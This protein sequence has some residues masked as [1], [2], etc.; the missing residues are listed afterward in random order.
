MEFSFGTLVFVIEFTVYLYIELYS[1]YRYR[2]FK[3][4]ADLNLLIAFSL[5]LLTAIERYYITFLTDMA[6]I[7]GIY[8][9]INFFLM[10]EIFFMY[11]A[12]T[13]Y[14]ENK[15]TTSVFVFAFISGIL[16]GAFL[17]D[18][19][20][21][22]AYDATTKNYNAVYS[23]AL[24][25]FIAPLI[26][27][28][29][30][31]IVQPL[32]RKSKSVVD[33]GDKRQIYMMAFGILLI[34]TWGVGA[35]LT[36]IPWLRML[37][38]L[39]FASGWIIWFLASRK[40]PFFLSISNARPK[41][42][43]VSD[44][45]GHLY[46]NY[47]FDKTTEYEPELVTPLVSAVNMIAHDVFKSSNGIEQFKMGESVVIIINE[48]RFYYYLLATNLDDTLKGLLRFFAKESL[49]ALKVTP[50]HSTADL[51]SLIGHTFNKLQIIDKEITT[52]PTVE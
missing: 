47:A 16:T 38:P 45:S 25:L 31:R 15:L 43:Y 49:D 11:N 1:I 9:S 10:I 19:T 22:V 33:K 40:D 27:F 35:I 41:A 17:Y 13:I 20:F 50:N 29:F 42:I 3:Y 39:L 5:A 52:I 48:D 7:T 4:I 2:R 28:A 23:K 6:V 32:L 14:Y 24:L 18:P 36:S 37:R 26:L 46:F 51:N 21:M 12:F 8:R 34:L 44:N 30:V